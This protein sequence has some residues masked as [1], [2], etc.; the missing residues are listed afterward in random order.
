[1]KTGPLFNINTTLLLSVCLWLAAVAAGCS[2]TAAGTTVHKQAAQAQPLLLFQKTRCYGACPAY[3]AIIY[4]DGSLR[5]EGIARVPAI[6]TLRLRLSKHEMIHI[7]KEIQALQYHA[8]A[9]TYSSQWTDMPATYLTF[10]Q[11]GKEIKRIKHQEGGP[12]QLLNFQ[13]Q[14]HQ[15]ILHLVENKPQADRAK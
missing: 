10:Y 9:N 1:M 2:S 14:L 15:L 11:D 7:R 13:Q 12:R 5:F 3:N 6:D 8:L 4:E